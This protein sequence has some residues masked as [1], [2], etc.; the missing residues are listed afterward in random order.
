I[1]LLI[2]VTCSSKAELSGKIEN[3]DVIADTL[4]YGVCLLGDKRESK[5]YLKNTGDKT[6]KL[7]KTK[8]SY[9]IERIGI[10]GHDYDHEE[11]SNNLVNDTLLI[12]PDDSAEIIISYEPD[13]DFASHPY[14]KKIV[15][16]LLGMYDSVLVWT[17]DT[18]L[19][20]VYKEYILIVRKVKYP[21]NGF[22]TYYNFDSVYVNPVYPIEYEWKVTNA[23]N[24][25]LEI[26]TQK[27]DPSTSQDITFENKDLPVQMPK[28][29]DP[30]T[31]MIEYNPTGRDEDSVKCSLGYIF[32]DTLRFAGIEIRGVGVEQDLI[33]IDTD[34]QSFDKE[35]DTI[36]IG[37]VSVG[38]NK[39]I[40]V[41]FGNDGN[42]NFGAG[43]QVIYDQLEGDIPSE[44]FSIVDSI[45]T[46]RHFVKTHG[47]TFKINFN[48]D[49]RGKFE[50]RYIIDSD[51]GS[52]NI[53]G[54]PA[55]ARQAVFF[56]KG[57]GIEPQLVAE[58][59]TVNFGTVVWHPDC[60]SSNTIT[61]KLR[62]TG[63][64]QLQIFSIDDTAPF[65]VE[66]FNNKI[67]EF[68]EPLAEDSINIIFSPNIQEDYFSEI[69]FTTNAN[70]PRDK[71]I[72]HLTASRI[73]PDS[74]R[75]S[76]PRDLKSKPGNPITIPILVNSKTINK[77]RT[78][79]T[80]LTFNRTLMGYLSY[81]KLGTASENTDDPDI[82]IREING[83]GKLS[84]FFETPAE[85]VYF[86]QRDTL[87]KLNFNTYI[88]DELSTSI[89]FIDPLLGDGVCDKV[90][91]PLDTNGVFTIDSICGLSYK[92]LPPGSGHFFIGE[93]IPN[94]ASDIVRL[95]YT[96]KYD[97]ELE[98]RLF[99]HM[100]VHVK[101]ITD[102]LQKAGLYELTF[103][104]S[105]LS[106]G[107]Y[108]LRFRAGLLSITKKL[109]ISR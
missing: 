78:F 27:T 10:P 33:I 70:P 40:F 93:F 81:S 59:D 61:L 60:Q 71:V 96:L 1:L 101:D 31:W 91:L 77:A 98:V 15:R 58:R 32:N 22:E 86:L 56:L 44:S 55:D 8:P 106:N 28:H 38:K 20:S 105:K 11:F 42:L 68:I 51:I 29:C 19:Y 12:L 79:K 94:P 45:P 39:E 66:F 102:G 30:V 34:A 74:I 97:Q 49:R 67:L 4:D 17:Q 103:S 5:F 41:A 63:N 43:K 26:H 13:N 18:N 109:V 24:Y 100:G 25:N 16:L 80:D 21:I 35:N 92:L 23:S 14:G 82:D 88:G 99:N 90:L 83:G 3:P 48:P 75:I 62:N 9:S 46:D 69:V 89:A 53:R 85:Q 84:I 47:D 104:C 64:T 65:K 37:R 107:V 76:I 73:D 2:V 52:R 57:E 50:A 54:V 6:L 95:E 72:V 36:D 7:R 87:I 108:Y